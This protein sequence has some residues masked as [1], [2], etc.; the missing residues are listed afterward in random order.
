M[1]LHLMATQG[2]LQLGVTDVRLLLQ[3]RDLLHE[4]GLG[5]VVLFRCHGLPRA[6]HN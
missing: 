5:F 3:S 4:L 6:R 2:L 1:T